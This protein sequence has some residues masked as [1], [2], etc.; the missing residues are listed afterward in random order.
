MSW[1]QE[2]VFERTLTFCATRMKKKVIIFHLIN[3][4]SDSRRWVFV[5]FICKIRLMWK[6]CEHHHCLL[7][8]SVIVVA[9]VVL[10]IWL[11]W[12]DTTAFLD[13]TFISFCCCWLLFFARFHFTSE[14]KWI[15]CKIYWIL[16]QR[17][18]YLYLK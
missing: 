2:T 7:S 13:N 14:P 9:V 18:I 1:N 11:E 12:T 10:M 5:V 8:F 15:L 3:S 4:H 6:R 17:K 16:K